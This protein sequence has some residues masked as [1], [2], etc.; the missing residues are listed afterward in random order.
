MKKT[1][2]VVMLPTE[3]AS[4][5]YIFGNNK[6]GY[7]KTIVSSSKNCNDQH[8]YI[9]SDDKIKEGKYRTDKT[10]EEYYK[11]TFKQD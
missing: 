3:K 7:D 9:I 6:L 8:L 5:L 10:A 1:F 11:E 2:N 4:N